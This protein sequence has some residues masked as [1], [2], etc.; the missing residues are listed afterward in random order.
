MNNT[1][2]GSV[3]RN[4]N[5]DITLSF[6]T[7][8]GVVSYTAPPNIW[9][10]HFCDASLGGESNFRFYTAMKFLNSTGPIDVLRVPPEFEGL[11]SHA[12]E[13]VTQ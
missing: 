3:T 11:P 7:N 12:S 4:P 6:R 9:A 13:H 1:A 5:G 10:S 8:A 2:T